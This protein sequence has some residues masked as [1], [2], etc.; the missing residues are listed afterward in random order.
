MRD[1]K[2]K[3]VIITGV[4]GF[5]GSYT[6]ALFLLNGA[7]VYGLVRPGSEEKTGNALRTALHSFDTALGRRVL[8]AGSE[9]AGRDIIR[10]GEEVLRDFHMV[11]GSLQ[12]MESLSGLPDQAEL[13]LHF[14]W[15]GVNREEIDDESIHRK[16]EKLSLS[17]IRLASGL[18]VK[19]FMDAGSRVEYGIKPDGIMKEGM[20]CDPINAYGRNKLLFYREASTLCSSL[21]IDYIHLRYFSVYGRGDHPWSI[22]ATLT[23]ELPKGRSVQLSACRHRW[24]F[25][26]VRDAALAVFEL[27]L[28][29]DQGLLREGSAIVNIASEDTRVLKAFVE[30]IYEL[31]GKRGSLSFGS[32][33]QAKEGPLSIVP[34]VE[35]LKRLTGGHFHECISFSEGIRELLEAAETEG[36]L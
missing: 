1:I 14:A 11:P 36:S 17:C 10:T 26:E 5:L 15:G 22:I 24:N 12:D 32:F 35:E 7:R 33:Q 25:M 6:A 27:Y 21:G 31:S 29:S 19:L 28:K 18:K 30:E 16:N 23:R 9:A 3:N 2:D 34:S 13:F 8:G 4:S 20:D